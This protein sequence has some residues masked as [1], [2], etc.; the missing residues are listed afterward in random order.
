MAAPS[1]SNCGPVTTDPRI[2]AGTAKRRG[3]I[4]SHTILEHL[5]L[6]QTVLCTL[7]G[8]HALTGSDPTYYIAGHSKK[9]CWKTF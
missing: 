9:T 4:P 2:L 8:L 7:L 1:M 3:Y 5:S 6:D